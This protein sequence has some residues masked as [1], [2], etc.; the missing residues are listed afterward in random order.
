MSLG[1][2]LS[3]SQMVIEWPMA[4]KAARQSMFMEQGQVV[5]PPSQTSHFL[6]VGPSLAATVWPGLV[7]HS[8]KGT[9]ASQS[10]DQC[11]RVRCAIKAISQ[12]S[13][14]TD[15]HPVI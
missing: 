2:M 5:G 9:A 11:Q 7:S 13:G 8:H 15:R 10:V 1:R 3:Y 14:V 12:G 4:V 6:P